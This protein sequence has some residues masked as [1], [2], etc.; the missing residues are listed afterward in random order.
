MYALAA[1]GKRQEA[2]ECGETAIA[3]AQANGESALAER[4]QSWL[5]KYRSERP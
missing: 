1:L 2:I 3:Q 4:I 5:T